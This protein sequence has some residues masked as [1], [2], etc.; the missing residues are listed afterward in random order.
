MPHDS[1]MCKKGC[2]KWNLCCFLLDQGG[3][4]RDQRVLSCSLSLKRSN[5]VPYSLLM[6][7]GLRRESGRAPY[8]IFERARERGMN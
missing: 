4:E 2:I 6:I 5:L 1:G 7:C 8:G 3:Q